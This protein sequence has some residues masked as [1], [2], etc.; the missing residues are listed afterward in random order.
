MSQ[1][2]AVFQLS[3]GKNRVWG[4]FFGWGFFLVAWLDF[5]FRKRKNCSGFK[6][7]IKFCQFHRSALQEIFSL[8]SSLQ[9][10]FRSTLT[11]LDTHQSACRPISI[12]AFF[13][14]FISP[15]DTKLTMLW[16]FSICSPAISW[17]RLVKKVL[18]EALQ[19]LLATC[20]PAWSA[21]NYLICCWS[22]T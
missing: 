5:F 14:F 1:C 6:T 21:L 11:L 15:R 7:T 17:Q 2:H 3:Q 9:R 16:S 8:S 12:S 18:K 20:L 19:P 13:F 22:V 10:A 4:F